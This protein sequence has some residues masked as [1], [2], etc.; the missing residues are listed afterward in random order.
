MFKTSLN[1]EI[2]EEVIAWVGQE[3][4][5]NTLLITIEI[6]T[7]IFERDQ[8]QYITEVYEKIGTN[9]NRLKVHGFK[10]NKM[11]DETRKLV[12]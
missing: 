2:R 1:Q 3:E 11:R 8:T 7:I 9:F 10:P 5:E 12:E 4:W 6:I